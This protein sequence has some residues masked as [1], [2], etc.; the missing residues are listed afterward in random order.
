MQKLDVKMQ[1]K[2]ETTMRLP[3]IMIQGWK[4]SL[5]GFLLGS[6]A[7]FFRGGDEYLFKGSGA[8]ENK[9]QT[10]QAGEL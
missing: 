9:V 10:G 6:Q 4:T 8:P 7:P 1:H 2:N 5:A 3:H